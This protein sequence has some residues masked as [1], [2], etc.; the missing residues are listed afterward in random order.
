[1][2]TETASARR[3]TAFL[4]HPAGLGWLAATEYWERFSYYGMLTLLVLY[5]NHQLLQHGH[6][7]HVWEFEAFRHFMTWL[8]GPLSPDALA[9]NIY[10]LYAGFVYLTPLFGGF[11]ADQFLGRTRTIILGACLMAAGHFLM[12][13]EQ[14]FLIALACLLAGVGCFKGNLATQVGDLYDHDDPRRADAFQIYY[15]SIQIAVILSPIICGWLADHEG[16]HWGFG[17]AGVGMLVGLA[18]YLAG[19]S[20]LPAEQRKTTAAPA[21]KT[22]PLTGA[23]WWTVGVLVLL[24]PVLALSNVGNSEIFNA[25][26]VWAEK[27]YQLS[28]FGF[29]IPTGWL[30][31]FDSIVSTATMAAS[32]IFWRWW[33]TKRREPDELAKM[34]LGVAISALAPLALALAS[35]AYVASGHRVSLWWAVAFELLNDIGFANVLPVGLALYSRAAPKKLEGTMVASYLLQLF[36]GNYLVGRLGGMLDTMPASRFWLMHAAIMAGAVVALVLIRLTA[37]RSLSPAYGEHAEAP[38][39]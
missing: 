23:E 25:Y 1:M 37:G 31:S 17:V 39:G 6:V 14:S 4:G 19:R 33:A 7:E 38:P 15:V 30:I 9:S 21:V 18:T 32:V 12:A 11:L 34:T 2:T 10:G 35:Q 27:Y 28:L 36:L 13:F 3:N 20:A 16:W 29:P 24:I 26:L 8:Y 5:M 22:A